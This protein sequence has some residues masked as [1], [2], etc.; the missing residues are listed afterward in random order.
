MSIMKSMALVSGK[1]L[2]DKL[3]YDKTKEEILTYMLERL[4]TN[5]IFLS[6]LAIFSSLLGFTSIAFIYYISFIL[7]RTRFGGW[8][9]NSPYTCMILSI[10]FPL[11]FSYVAIHITIPNY[12][13]IFTYVFAYFTAFYKGVVDNPNK[14]LKEFRKKRFKKQGLI[15]LTIICIIHTLIII[16]NLHLFSNILTLSLL[17]SFGN[18]YFGK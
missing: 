3:E 2:S 9:A 11:A 13:V 12:I 8:H 6:L 1:Y 18:L 10:I 5:I 7:I 16:N 17:S 15:I 14:R 4:I